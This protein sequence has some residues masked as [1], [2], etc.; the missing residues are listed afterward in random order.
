MKILII[1]KHEQ[2][3]FS[4]TEWTEEIFP[5]AEIDI[6]TSIYKEEVYESDYD[7]AIVHSGNEKDATLTYQENIGAEK[8]FY[9]GAL[10]TI[11]QIKPHVW[12]SPYDDIQ[13][14]LEILK[15]A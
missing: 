14:V 15:N 10:L 6:Y 1:D 7:I 11:K 5:D 8:I 4:L 9:S 12:Y 13:T 3:H 2:R